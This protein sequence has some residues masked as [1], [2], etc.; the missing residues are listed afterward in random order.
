MDRRKESEMKTSEK[1]KDIE[2]QLYNKFPLGKIGAFNIEHLIKEVEALEE[3]TTDKD[4]ELK[5]QIL[6][7]V[8]SVGN[9]F[10]DHAEGNHSLEHGTIKLAIKAE[11][12]S[13]E[14]ILNAFKEGL[15]E[16]W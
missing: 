6:E 16:N 14:E 15:E 9:Y 8:H 2:T 3:K 13:K 7:A 12:I 5:N 4:V 10:V 1:L 11:L